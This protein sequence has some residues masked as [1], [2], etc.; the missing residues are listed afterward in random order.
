MERGADAI[1]ITILFHPNRLTLYEQTSNIQINKN[2]I[3]LLIPE[4]ISSKM[5]AFSK[6]D[7][8]SM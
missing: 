7:G 5:I 1:Y 8:V 6:W 3:L 4:Q 2:L